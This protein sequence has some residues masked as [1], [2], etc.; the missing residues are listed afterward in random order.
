MRDFHKTF[1]SYNVAIVSID[2]QQGLN[3]ECIGTAR[4]YD[5]KRGLGIGSE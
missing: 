5:D 1:N 2:F 3:N 4:V